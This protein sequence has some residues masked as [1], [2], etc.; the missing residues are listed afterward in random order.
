MKEFL[1][2][3]ISHPYFAIGSVHTHM[4]A[5]I[6]TTWVLFLSFP[7]VSAWFELLIPPRCSPTFQL[8]FILPCSVVF[9]LM[10]EPSHPTIFKYNDKI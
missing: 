8:C 9:I 1:Y 10:I 6:K 3:L 5:H 7:D 4:R 2:Y